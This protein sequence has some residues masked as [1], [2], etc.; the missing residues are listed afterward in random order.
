[1]GE[2]GYMPPSAC[3]VDVKVFRQLEADNQQ[4]ENENRRLDND[5]RL[6]H[7]AEADRVRRIGHVQLWQALDSEVREL[8]AVL[9]SEALLAA[10]QETNE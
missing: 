1:M 9:Q 3:A 4:L 8:F 7:E 2:G 10:P 6:W 5:A